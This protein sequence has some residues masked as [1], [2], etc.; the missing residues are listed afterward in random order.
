MRN[1][2]MITNQPVGSKS[3]DLSCFTSNPEK[4]PRDNILGNSFI[5]VPLNVRLSQ[6]LNNDGSKPAS[7]LSPS[8]MNKTSLDYQK[9]KMN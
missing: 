7:H 4:T 5:D 8:A 9:S 6:F 2:A 3:I 1:L